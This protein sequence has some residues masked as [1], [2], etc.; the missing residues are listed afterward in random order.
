MA[1]VR[2]RPETGR[3]YLDFT[4]K[5][6]RCREHTALI[7]SPSNRKLAEQLMK[8]IQHQITLGTFEYEKIFPG[9]PRAKWFMETE[10]EVFVNPAAVGQAHT[11]NIPRFREF[12]EV[13]INES[14]P[15]WKPSYEETVI[16]TLNKYLLPKFNN[17]NVASITRAD[18]LGYRAELARKISTTTGRP[19]SSARINK[20]MGFARQ[21]LN[22]AADRYEFKRAFEGIKPLRQKKPDIE[23]FTMDEIN[24]ILKTVRPDFRNY[25]AVRFWTG[26]RTS[27]A[28]GLRWE[29]IDFENEMILVRETYV[30][31]VLQES[32]KTYESARDIPMLGPVKKALMEQR[33]R[34]PTD[35]EW[36][37]C[38]KAGNP[39]N[40]QNFTRRVWRPL[41]K[42]LN[43]KYRRPY[44][45]RH[46][47]ATLML[48][49][50]EAPEWVAR[51]LG[52]STTEML[53]RVYSRYVPNVTRKDGSAMT[54]LLNSS[55]EGAFAEE[56]NKEDV[57][58]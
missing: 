51:T 21:I 44:Q 6:I 49:S 37:F 17:E 52:H 58:K 8:R 2:V 41:L 31:G 20:I 46:T 53:F 54:R 16:G 19:L 42:S 38:N 30:R 13:W 5:G 55:T 57:E 34:V 14:Q 47:A 25:L 50:G 35:I 9:S 48:A 1:N 45:T 10:P 28:N 26:L 23:P 24:L 56:D 22:E 33:K 29:R 3:L 12:V 43:L 40:N 15:M 36:V 7:D 18:L 11:D 27:E 4:Y 32:T 39:I